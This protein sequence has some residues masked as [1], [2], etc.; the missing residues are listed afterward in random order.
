MAAEV[1]CGTCGQSN[2]VARRF[3]GECGA[4]LSAACPSCGVVDDGRR[5]RRETGATQAFSQRGEPNW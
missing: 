1:V 3:C 5:V 2:R 4:A